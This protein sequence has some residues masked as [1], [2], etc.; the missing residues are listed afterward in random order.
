MLV[1]RYL[2]ADS[3]AISTSELSRVRHAGARS[4]RSEARHERH[5]PHHGRVSGD[6]MG[7]HVSFVVAVARP[8]AFAQST[9]GYEDYAA[10]LATA[11]ASRR[12][13]NS[14]ARPTRS[15]S[16]R[17]NGICDATTQGVEAH[18]RRF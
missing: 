6:G 13:A 16:P 5:H 2:R 12:S 18:L 15:G 7:T 3:F 4:D 8:V 11:L 9:S 10:G 14:S 1:A 17:A